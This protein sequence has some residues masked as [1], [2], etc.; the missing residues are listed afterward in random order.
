MER[1]NGADLA[2]HVDGMVIRQL[3]FSTAVAV[4]ASMLDKIEELLLASMDI[5]RDELTKDRMSLLISEVREV[6]E[7]AV[8][9]AEITNSRAK[10][11][12]AH[13]LR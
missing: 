2:S 8:N 4:A 1:S 5:T 6:K 12:L 13:D 11:S 9:L 7:H 3:C 10:T